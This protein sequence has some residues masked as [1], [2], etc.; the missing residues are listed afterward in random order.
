MVRFYNLVITSLV[1]ID[2]QYNYVSFVYNEK[3]K[4]QNIQRQLT[5][6]KSILDQS[7]KVIITKQIIDKIKNT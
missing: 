2:D 7:K 1:T 3:Q 5:I 6:N 4:L